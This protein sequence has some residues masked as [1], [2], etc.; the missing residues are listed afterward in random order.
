M[1]DISDVTIQRLLDAMYQLA[2]LTET[3]SK[4]VSRQE[5]DAI[6]LDAIKSDIDNLKAAQTMYNCNFGRQFEG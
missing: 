6:K 4:V 3:L 2:K 1:A 5:L